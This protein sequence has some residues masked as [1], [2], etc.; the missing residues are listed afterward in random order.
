METHNQHTGDTEQQV[1][2]NVAPSGYLYQTVDVVESGIGSD[3]ANVQK[4]GTGVLVGRNLL[5][6]S[7]EAA[8]RGQAS[9]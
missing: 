3:A 5:L 8:P 4:R 7:S 9:S 2:V 6:T 1:A